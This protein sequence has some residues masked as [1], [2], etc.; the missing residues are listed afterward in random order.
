[1]KANTTS[2]RE[3]KTDFI[4]MIMEQN[5]RVKRI[6]E[7]QAYSESVSK[8]KQSK[9]RSKVTDAV[10]MIAMLLCIVGLAVGIVVKATTTEHGYYKRT[11]TMQSNDN[12][13]VFV[14]E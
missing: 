9:K 6:K 2:T 1:M 10:I 3:I 12:Y 5:A 7:A 4:P 14:T 11:E 8:R 13:Y